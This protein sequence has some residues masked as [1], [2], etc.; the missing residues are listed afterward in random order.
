ML[1]SAPGSMIPIARP[2]LGEEEEIGVLEVRRSGWVTQGPR[3][4]QFE[5]K[6]ARYVGCD[7]AIAVSF[8]TTALQPFGSTPGAPRPSPSANDAALNS[9]TRSRHPGENL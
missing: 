5:E 3:V 4:A 7:Y 9:A 8:C 1:I 6:F 2:F